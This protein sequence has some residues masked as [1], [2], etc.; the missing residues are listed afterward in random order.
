MMGNDAWRQLLD[1]ESRDL[2]SKYIE[3]NYNRKASERQILEISANFKQGR[4]YFRNAQASDIT[5]KP[6]LLFYGIQTLSRGLYLCL[7]PRIASSTLTPSHGLTT[8]K[9]QE[10]LAVPRFDE[11]TVKTCKGGF[12]DILE[13]SENTSL[14]KLRSNKISGHVQFS[15][16]KENQVIKLN[17]LLRTFPDLARTYTN[18]SGENVSFLSLEG[19]RVKEDGIVSLEFAQ[20]AKVELI[21]ELITKEF[22]NDD[23][24]RT[25]TGQKKFT[26]HTMPQISQRFLDPF[27]MGIAD[28]VVSPSI[29]ELRL[30]ILGQFYALGYFLGMLSRYFP[31]KW[32]ALGQTRT[33]DSFFPMAI[34][35]IRLLEDH[36][37]QVIVDYLESFNRLTND[38]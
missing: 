2:I 8:F 28:I 4:E 26:V 18:W 6:L 24:V 36:F 38:I 9:W 35:S 3:E 17:Q 7:A 14:L 21:T 1:F 25:E 22:T 20:S 27:N 32:M 12:I 34:D 33:G 23:F 11:L 16:P 19:M 29:Q 30:N 5:V 13:V 10:T 31:S 15:M 37:P